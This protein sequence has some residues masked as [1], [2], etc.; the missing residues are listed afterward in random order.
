MLL[1]TSMAH[2]FIAVVII[3]VICL[4][5]AAVLRADSALPGIDCC[6]WDPYRSACGNLLNLVQRHRGEGTR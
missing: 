5:P 2:A 6:S 3:A 4:G 1:R